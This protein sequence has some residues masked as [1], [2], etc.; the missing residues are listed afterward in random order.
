[1]GFGPWKFESSSPHHSNLLEGEE[2]NAELHADFRPAYGRLPGCTQQE[3]D[4]ALSPQQGVRLLQNGKTYLNV[5][6]SVFGMG[7][8]R[9]NLDFPRKEAAQLKGSQ[10]L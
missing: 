8:I 7:E 1:M 4:P 2:S 5:H 10:S 9:S 3:G 6:T